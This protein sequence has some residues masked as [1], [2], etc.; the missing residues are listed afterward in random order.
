MKD[1]APEMIDEQEYRDAI[2]F[3]DARAIAFAS[4]THYDTYP[5]NLRCTVEPSIPDDEEPIGD[6][7]NQGEHIALSEARPALPCGRSFR[8]R[9]EDAQVSDT[10]GYIILNR[11]PSG[12]WFVTESPF[13]EAPVY[14][15]RETAIKC[16]EDQEFV[17]EIRLPFVKETK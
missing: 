4:L 15:D 11:H 13:R 5:I 8:T 17:Y 6:W 2:A 10:K 9:S 3:V 7:W 14:M 1:Q 16:A 12:D